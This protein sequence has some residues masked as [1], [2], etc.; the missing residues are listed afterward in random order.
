MRK[1]YPVRRSDL[2]RIAR[3]IAA[4][5]VPTLIAG[6]LAHRAGVIDAPDLRKVLIASVTLGL[7]GGIMSCLAIASWWNRGGIGVADAARG[8]F[9]ALLLLMPAGAVVTASAAFP[10]LTE[11]STDLQ[12]PPRAM[13]EP[14]LPAS[15][16]GLVA[17]ELAQ[18]AAYPDIVSRRFRITPG[19][20]HAA[21]L[22]VVEKQQWR[23]IGE[24][25]PDMQDAPTLLEVETRVP[26]LA[27]S[28]DLTIRIRPDRAGAVLDVRAASDL[29]DHDLGLNAW[30]IRGFYRQLDEMLTESYGDIAKLTVTPEEAA[31]IEAEELP[32]LADRPLADAAASVPLPSM[33]PSGAQTVPALAP[34]QFDEIYEEDP[35]PAR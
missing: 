25:P 21:V 12:D 7:A 24:V 22:K 23:I 15:D 34:A 28:N 11:V 29:K 31:A 30:R 35:A 27:L 26:V 4:L 33:K 18:R 16:P 13:P 10:P 9:Y 6:I 20:L 2:A 14:G 5:G 3:F 17:R 8:L 32:L 1:R 19:D